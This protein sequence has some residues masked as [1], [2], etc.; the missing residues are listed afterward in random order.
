MRQATHATLASAWIVCA[1]A[2]AL[3]AGLA[4]G[5]AA[6]DWPQWGGSDSRIMAS[7]SARGLP[8]WFDPG[9]MGYDALTDPPTTRNVKWAFRLPNSYNFNSP[10]A[11][12]GRLIAGG[13]PL[14]CLDQETGRTLWAFVAPKAH[15]QPGLIEIGTYGF[16]STATIVGDRVYVLAPDGTV[17]ALDLF[18]EKDP[19]C[20]HSSQ[21]PAPARVLWQYDLIDSLQVNPHHAASCSVLAHGDYLYVCTGNSRPEQHKVDRGNKFF[22]LSPSLIALGKDSGRLVAR[23]DEQIGL[24]LYKGQWS[25]PSLG[26]VN[27]K[28]QV[29]L[30]AGDGVCYA[31]ETVDPNQPVPT[32]DRWLIAKARGQVIQFDEIG[33]GPTAAGARPADLQVVRWPVLQEKPADILIAE[34][35]VPDVPVLK[36]IWWFD[37]VPRRLK[38]GP[39]TEPIPYRHKNGPSY[40]VATS[41]FFNNRVY[42]AIGQDPSIGGGKG[43]LVCI[44][45]TKTGDVTESGLVWE[46]NQIDRSAS[47]VAIAG[48]MVFAADVS[49][50][51]HCLDAETGKLY[52][53]RTTAEGELWGSPIA[54]DGKVYLGTR[55]GLVVMAAAREFKLL[56]VVR[57][58]SSCAATPCAVNNVLFVP[59][60]KY[61]RA[62]CDKGDKLSP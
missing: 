58:E 19:S 35:R 21:P 9:T 36:K 50:T 24:R 40:I 31:F 55:K 45:A 30:G 17:C 13:G 32:E 47:T 12:Q 51:V 46:Y 2:V 1:A 61:L 34:A 7:P 59:S 41:A 4:T 48:G 6:A 53:A 27:G 43:R 44:D 3:A 49:G 33:K 15:R 18:S 62:V 57:L 14:L 29:F 37:C 56:S 20:G 26:M 5:L 42:L 52:W 60:Q 11:S 38:V 54:A 25:S 8:E 10:V 39:D 23:D 16:T 22:P 28:A